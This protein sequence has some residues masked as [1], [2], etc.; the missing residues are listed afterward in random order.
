MFQISLSNYKLLGGF[1]PRVATIKNILNYYD[2]A[3]PHT[4][5]PFTEAMLFGIGGGLGM[6]YILWQFKKHKIPDLILGFQNKWNYPVKFTI[7]LLSRIGAKY[8]IKETVDE[9]NAQ[10]NLELALNKQIPSIVW[11]PTD[12]LT[13]LNKN[14]MDYSVK[15]RMVVVIGEEESGKS[16]ESN[17]KRIIIDD[18]GIEPFIMKFKD[19][20]EARSR[21]PYN[22]NRLLITHPPEKI[23]LKQAIIEGIRDCVDNMTIPS[24]SFSLPGLK[25]WSRALNDEKIKK[26]WSTVFSKGVG[27][28]SALKTI[29]EAIKYGESDGTGLRKMYSEFILEANN[30]IDAGPLE[31]IADHY[32]DIGK[33]WSDLAE[34][35]LPLD[36]FSETRD[37]LSRKYKL[38]QEKGDKGIQQIHEIDE[39]LEKIRIEFD[40]N[41][42][43]FMNKVG[44]LLSQL[45]YQ[46]NNIYIEEKQAISDLK[47][48]IKEVED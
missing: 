8:E 48:A 10:K 38:R 46:I 9:N 47:I 3:A 21:I 15:S 43:M 36:Y 26:S 5:E 29:Y 22:K 28:Y 31:Q 27:L 13:L 23:Q 19:F 33:F 25:K 12:Y 1:N 6:G 35:S 44:R 11:V 32:R 17:G 37:L 45:N 40:S 41:F 18:L 7:N 2:I 34:T 20:Q 30:I 24:Q 14:S 39:K 16:D 4:E 42:P